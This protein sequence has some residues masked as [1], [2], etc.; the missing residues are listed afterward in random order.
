MSAPCFV[1]VKLMKE[2]Y[3]LPAFLKN[4]PIFALD[5]MI[6]I[7]VYIQHLQSNSE[8]SSG[9]STEKKK[10]A[11]WQRSVGG[12]S[13]SK[14][15][16]G[17]LVKKKQPS[18]NQQ[19]QKIVT[20]TSKDSTADSIESSEMD[21]KKDESAPVNDDN[22]K[23]EIGTETKAEPKKTVPSGLGLLGSYSDSESNGSESD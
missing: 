3:N 5:K 19:E 6:Q 18:L 10:P 2:Y 13:S 1:S 22:A 15:A 8:S 9:S 12:L 7:I 4:S 21:N 20:S 11:S 16:L 23:T 14:S 17:M